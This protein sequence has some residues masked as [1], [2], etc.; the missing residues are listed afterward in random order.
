M[1]N[2][3]ARP[4]I[5]ITMGDPLGI[6]PEILVKAL[7]QSDIYLQCKP[8]VIGDKNIIEQAVKLID[9]SFEINLIEQANQGKYKFKTIDL[10]N[11]S[12]LKKDVSTLSGPSVE[13]GSA[14][15]DYIIKGI[16]LAL[17]GLK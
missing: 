9:S 5:G 7:T 15:Q 11:L 2:I 10:L 13:T 4:I 14:M 17:T 16:D 1:K 12:N 3:S 6:G 8:L